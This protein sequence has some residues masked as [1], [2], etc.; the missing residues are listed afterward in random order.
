MP[1]IAEDLWSDE[2]V[3]DL[4]AERGQE[5]SK[6]DIN[7]STEQK[8]YES[9]SSTP[10]STFEQQQQQQQQDQE[11]DDD[12]DDSRWS[13]H[14]HRSG[15]ET[16]RDEEQ[17]E[18]EK[19][20]GATTDLETIWETLVRQVPAAEIDEIRRILG[21]RSVEENQDL[22]KEVRSIK[23]ILSDLYNSHEEA[24]AKHQ[25]QQQSL[26]AMPVS[27]TRAMLEDQIALLLRFLSEREAGSAISGVGGAALGAARLLQANQN[28][29]TSPVQTNDNDTPR[30]SLAVPA[31]VHLPS[32]AEGKYYFGLTS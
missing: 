31:S 30:Q 9:G 15:T 16:H 6:F 7:T 24:R 5:E 3:F 2:R 32:N 19:Y 1:F 20:D 13:R 25:E 28:V 21:Y 11:E 4:P 23:E 8:K 10:R 17:E 26:A 27:R 14:T 18:E 22:A 29:S 12:N